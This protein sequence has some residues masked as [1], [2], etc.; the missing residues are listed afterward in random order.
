MRK[1]N[2][3]MKKTKL[4][5]KK[6]KNPKINTRRRSMNN[7]MKKK[8]ANKKLKEEADTKVKDIKEKNTLKIHVMLEI[9]HLDL[10][11]LFPVPPMCAWASNFLKKWH[12]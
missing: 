12:N 6:K 8:I 7:K 1:E 2:K 10:R 3:K 4:Q 9:K 5:K 11:E